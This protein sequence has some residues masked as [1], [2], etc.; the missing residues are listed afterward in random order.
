MLLL[1]NAHTFIHYSL[2]S[3]CSICSFLHLLALNVDYDYRLIFV[4]ST[5]IAE[6]E[7]IRH[8]QSRDTRVFWVEPRVFRQVTDHCPPLVVTLW[9]LV[10]RGKFADQIVNLE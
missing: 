3:T 9:L 7:K 5:Y 4:L 6:N 2:C 1:H 10:K 8:V